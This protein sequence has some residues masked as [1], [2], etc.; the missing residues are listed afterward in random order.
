MLNEQEVRKIIKEELEAF[1]QEELGK[2][3]H[4]EL[5]A[6]SIETLEIIKLI[7]PRHLENCLNEKL[8]NEHK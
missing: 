6:F 4:H 8:K 7:I 2:V 3:I 1:S 5:C